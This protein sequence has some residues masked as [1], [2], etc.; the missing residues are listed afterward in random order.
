VTPVRPPLTHAVP[1][2]EAVGP[3]KA[4]MET[5]LAATA[6]IID[7]FMRTWTPQV[8]IA[9]EGLAPERTPRVGRRLLSAAAMLT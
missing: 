9:E 6:P 3:N 4:A 7:E 1:L 5:M 2:A 8:D